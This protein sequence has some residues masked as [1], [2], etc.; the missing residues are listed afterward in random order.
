MGVPPTEP[1]V[2]FMQHTLKMRGAHKSIELPGLVRRYLYNAYLKPLGCQ[3]MFKR[4]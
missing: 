1:L 4:F 2:N 3:G